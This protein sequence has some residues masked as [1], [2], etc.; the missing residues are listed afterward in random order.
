MKMI[1]LEKILRSLQEMSP[2]ITVPEPIRE[3]AYAPV[4]RM[5][6]IV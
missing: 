4:K 1:S 5:L 2:V 6:E 3:K